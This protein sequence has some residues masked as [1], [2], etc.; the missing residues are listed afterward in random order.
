MEIIINKSNHLPWYYP[1]H[2]IFASTTGSCMH[3]NFSSLA[4]TVKRRTLLMSLLYGSLLTAFAVFSASQSDQN[5]SREAH[6]G[7]SV[8]L[9]NNLVS[10]THQPVLPAGENKESS[11]EQEKEEKKEDNR[12][13]KSPVHACL[14]PAGYPI[15]STFCENQLCPGKLS[16]SLSVPLYVLF[17]NWKHHLSA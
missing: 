8:T 3:F 9:T 15:F 10:D 13:D 7:S 14:G 4:F 5:T 6:S 12:D 16:P 11:A 17:H 1:D 2:S